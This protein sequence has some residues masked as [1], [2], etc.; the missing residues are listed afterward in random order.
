[1]SNFNNNARHKYSY[2][3]IARPRFVSTRGQQQVHRS[4]LQRLC[5]ALKQLRVA[6]A[7]QI[8]KKRAIPHAFVV[9]LVTDAATVAA[10]VERG[11]DV[12]RQASLDGKRQRVE[13]TAST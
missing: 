9:I 8:A 5:R 6:A 2:L 3:N 7:H 10:D 13:E 1:M 4:M 12:N 11:V